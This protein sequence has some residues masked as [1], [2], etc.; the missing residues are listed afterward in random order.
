VRALHLVEVQGAGDAVEHLVGY[1]ADVAAFQP[2][3]VLDRDA[4]QQRHFVPAQPG[5]P[6]SA[7]VIRQ[8]RPLRGDLGASG[9]Q[10]FPDLAADVCH[11]GHGS[12]ARQACGR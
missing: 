1:A 5:N 4:S 7:P 8:A 6:P 2:G 9:G 3:V 12:E 11:V 10:E